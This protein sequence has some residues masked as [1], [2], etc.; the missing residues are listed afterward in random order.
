M[1]FQTLRVFWN[2]CHIVIVIAGDWDCYGGND[3]NNDGSKNNQKNI[4]MVKHE[5]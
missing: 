5:K 2:Q 1:K 3:W 4:L